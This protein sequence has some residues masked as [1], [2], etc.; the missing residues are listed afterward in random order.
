MA[1]QVDDKSKPKI[2]VYLINKGRLRCRATVT[3]FGTA[4]YYN[5]EW[6]TLLLENVIKAD[7]ETLVTKR[8][9]FKV[10]KWAQYLK[11][12]DYFEFEVRAVDYE[13]D[14]GWIL[15]HP[16]HVLILP[17]NTPKC[18][19]TK[20]LADLVDAIETAS[21]ASFRD[22]W[23][24]NFTLKYGFSENTL[25]AVTTEIRELNEA[26]QT[27]HKRQQILDMLIVAHET[28]VAIG[29]LKGSR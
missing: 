28:E 25:A 16:A 5:S 14:N 1:D 26:G 27:I 17:K 19:N 10:G 15:S 8:Q 11:L 20:A 23:A 29:A 21:Q 3:E 4:A 6:K 7:T 2:R 24:N 18:D 13:S 12:G 22:G 9:W